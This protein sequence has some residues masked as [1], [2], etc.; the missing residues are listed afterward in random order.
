MAPFRTRAALPLAAVVVLPVLAA[1][2]SSPASASGDREARPVGVVERRAAASLDYSPKLFVG[3]QKLTFTGDLGVRG[4]RVIRLQMHLNRPGDEWITIDGFRRRTQRD[5]SFRFGYLA[6]SMRDK[7]MRVRGK[8]GYVT[9]AHTFNARSQDLVLLEAGTADVPLTTAEAGE[10]FDIKVDTTPVVKGRH[11]LPGPV[12]EGRALT[13]QRRVEPDPADPGHTQQW[14][15]LSRG[16]VVTD[17]QGIGVFEDVPDPAGT[18]AVVYR[19]RQEDWTRNGDDV[20]WFASFPTC[21]DVVG[22]YNSEPDCD[23]GDKVTYR[24]TS[25]RT[26]GS[27]GQGGSTTAGGEYGWGPA[28]WDFGWSKGE[29]LDTRPQRGRDA[30]G[31]WSAWSDGTGRAVP[32]NGQLMLDSQRE[33]RGIA[34]SRGTT[35]VTLRGNPMRYGRWEVRLRAS[36]SQQGEQE[37]RTR[38]ELVPNDPADYDCGARTITVV[39]YSP[40]RSSVRIG[41]REPR[42]SQW[43][44]TVEGLDLDNQNHAWAIEVARDHL[45]WFREGRPIGTVATSAA[46]PDVPMTLRMSIVGDEDGDRR[47]NKTQTYYDWMRGYSLEHGR[48]VTKDVPALRKGSFDAACPAPE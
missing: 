27:G 46:V 14:V 41:A 26:A 10:T 11:D 16:E 32:Q 45:T 38:I 3:G 36:T 40:L 42:G 47:I 23:R 29:D 48:Q 7:L 8:G 44:R 37:S 39:D 6:P 24:T 18:D 28:L 33:Y 15:T 21:V 12:F 30:E 17:G 5:G 13:L 34:N 19:V 20:G 22:P 25:V 9:P 43:T 35:M 4:R 1:P 31:R 2:T